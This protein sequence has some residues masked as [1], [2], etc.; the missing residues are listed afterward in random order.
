MKYSHESGVLTW[1]AVSVVKHRRRRSWHWM[2]HPDLR[3]MNVRGN[4]LTRWHWEGTVA[5]S[6]FSGSPS[7]MTYWVIGSIVRR[8]LELGNEL[9][10]FRRI[11]QNFWWI[12]WGGTT[13]GGVLYSRDPFPSVPV[14][15]AD[16]PR[17]PVFPRDICGGVGGFVVGGGPTE[18]VTPTDW[19]ELWLEPRCFCFMAAWA[20]ATPWP[21]SSNSE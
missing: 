17:V 16:F 19:M 5:G 1:H 10:N 21:T 12:T 7:G 15:P 3:S 6:T 2:N 13:T 20:E 4:L 18:E 14:L 8:N 11:L 9:V